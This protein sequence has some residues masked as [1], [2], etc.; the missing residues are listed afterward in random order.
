MAWYPLST[1]NQHSPVKPPIGTQLNRSHPLAQGLVGCWLFN[2]RSGVDSADAGNLAVYGDIVAIPDG[3][4]AFS[5]SI[6]ASCL[7][8]GKPLSL[9]SQL[10][11]VMDCRL[12]GL[13]GGYAHLIGNAN[14][15]GIECGLKYSAGVFYVHINN[16][17]A[18][19]SIP[20]P[21]NQGRGQIAL[22]VNGTEA[23][24]YRKGVL[25][26]T[27]TGTANTPT[28]MNFRVIGDGN[29]R[30][31][32]GDYHYCYVY[33][34]PLSALEIVSLNANPYQMFM[35][36]PM[37]V[38][39][40][41][42]GS[43]YDESISL[44]VSAAQTLGLLGNYSAALGLSCELNQAAARSAVYSAGLTM[45]TEAA[46]S[47]NKLFTGLAALPLLAS[48][49]FSV[50]CLAGLIGGVSLTSSVGMSVS[51]GGQVLATLLL[52][53]DAALAQSILGD[54]RGSCNLTTSAGVSQQ[55][56]LELSASLSVSC[57]A[58]I[59]IEVLQDLYA[60]ISIDTLATIG[61]QYYAVLAAVTKVLL[62]IRM[63]APTTS[64]DFKQANAGISIKQV[65]AGVELK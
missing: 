17:S 32:F 30:R 22:T 55:V 14:N 46:A 51:Y 60:G 47:G 52:E 40:G 35:Q 28:S 57:G 54:L 53:V 38:N 20:N 6:N 45:N 61:Q 29:S 3:I 9:G 15:G 65:D 4:N 58:T 39:L 62:A 34:R 42:S 64:A 21:V 37:W 10:T 13:S 7:D 1:D 36:P 26:A 43:T 18:G 63:Q 59:S 2:D 56:L 12:T 19:A 41:A 23:K 44:G 31:T 5:G 27:R 8:L 49:G 50:G 25:V 11:F 24:Y 16:L 48:S 33:N